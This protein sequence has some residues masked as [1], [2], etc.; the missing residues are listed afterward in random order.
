MKQMSEMYNLPYDGT[1]ITLKLI[2]LI[3]AQNRE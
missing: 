2:K 1:L 3:T